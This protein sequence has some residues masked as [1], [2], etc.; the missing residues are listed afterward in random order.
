MCQLKNKMN[1][2]ILRLNISH[3]YVSALHFQRVDIT[4]KYVTDGGFDAR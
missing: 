4:V 3:A 2:A 1:L